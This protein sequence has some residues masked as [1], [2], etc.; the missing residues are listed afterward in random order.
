MVVLELKPRR[1]LASIW[2]AAVVRGTGLA[3]LA[4]VFSRFCTL[5]LA[6]LNCS[7]KNLASSLVAKVVLSRLASKISEE[8]R[9]EILAAWS[10][11]LPV[12]LKLDLALKRSISCSRSTIRRRA[13]DWTRPADLAP[14]TLVRT[15]PERS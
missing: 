15:T 12:T 7:R 9:L 14:G 1:L 13:G 11:N 10:L 4:S 2:S 3:F 8:S 6:F 5:K